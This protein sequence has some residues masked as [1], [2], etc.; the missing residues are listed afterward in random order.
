MYEIPEK[1]YKLRRE[2]YDIWILCLGENKNIMR[3]EEVF[4]F[5]RS[6][7]QSLT[8]K[9]EVFNRIGQETIRSIQIKKNPNPLDKTVDP[10]CTVWEALPVDC[11]S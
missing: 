7:V 3:E 11:G 5:L 8:G 10:A 1:V 2:S 6:Y 9:W 4:F